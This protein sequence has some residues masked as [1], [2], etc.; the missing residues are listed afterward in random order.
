[1]PRQR[2]TRLLAG[3][4]GALLLP[5]LPAATE[6]TAP[7]H[8]V[9]AFD[10]FIVTSGP[11]CAARPAPDCVAVAWRFADRDGDRGLSVEE[12]QA[13]RDALG[14]WTAWRYDGLATTERSAIVLGLTLADAIGLER[15]LAAYDA[16]GDGLVSRAE[17][18]ADVV[19]DERPLAEVLRDPQALDRRAVAR[20]LGVLPQLLDPLEP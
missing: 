10:H 9:L 11:I 7:S 19:L 2:L 6:P 14:Q 13:V 8:G 1:L 5:L 12:L 3:L 18:L 16:D 4:L 15:L 20:R 17:L